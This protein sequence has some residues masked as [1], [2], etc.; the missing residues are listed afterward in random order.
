MRAIQSSLSLFEIDGHLSTDVPQV[1]RR[2]SELS[3]TSSE[4]LQVHQIL[5]TAS[6]VFIFER[7]IFGLLSSSL[8]LLFNNKLMNPPLVNL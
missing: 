7:L 4:S 8:F 5:L 2:T 1:A 6:L 3:L